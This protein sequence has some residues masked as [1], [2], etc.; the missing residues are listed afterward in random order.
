MMEGIRTAVV[1]GPTGAIGTALVERLIQEKVQVFAIVRRDSR[2]IAQIPEHPLVRN[3][4]LDLEHLEA[5]AEEIPAGCDVFYHFAWA[6]TFGE[7]RNDVYLQ[8]RNVAYTLDAVRLAARLGCR[9]FVGAG[10][11][12]EYGRTEGCLKPDTPAFP[13][14]GYGIA[15]L[16]AGQMSRLLCAR[17]GIEH[18][19]VRILSVY[20]PCDGE[21]TMVS[22]AIESILKKERPSFT[23]GEQEWD[24]LYSRDAAR[25][26]Y[27]LGEKG[28]SGKTYCLGSGTKYPLAHY[29]RRIRDAVDPDAEIGLGDLPY[30]EK[31]VM[32]LWADIS[33]LRKDTGFV[34]DYTF[35]KGIAETAAW[36]KRKKENEKN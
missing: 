31:Q 7:S 5:A 16:C 18:I 28:V 9:R 21:K 14:N 17:E 1:T 36:F 15:K 25:A 27:L 32:H 4:Y 33:E 29:I 26:F 3:I 10:S 8:N 34:P 35:E 2:R 20:G 24:Y 30:P 11:Q 13:E 19:W 6:G 23:R 12:A 22:S